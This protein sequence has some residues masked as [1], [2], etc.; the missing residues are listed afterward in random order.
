MICVECGAPAPSLI[1]K[2]TPSTVDVV[3]CSYCR[4]HPAD[5]YLEGPLLLVIQDLL[6]LRPQA[7]RHLIY[8]TSPSSGLPQPFSPSANH[9]RLIFIVASAIIHFAMIWS[10]TIQ[11]LPCFILPSNDP[12]AFPV[13]S[14]SSHAATLRL[15]SNGNPLALVSPSLSLSSL[16]TLPS[17]SR[18]VDVILPVSLARAKGCLL[19]TSSIDPPI[20]TAA[21]QVDLLACLVFS[22]I[23]TISLFIAH[24]T[25][26]ILS[27][28]FLSRRLTTFHDDSSIS[29]Q[30]SSSDNI[31]KPLS[32]LP[33]TINHALF[34]SSLPSLMHIFPLLWPPSIF[35]I[36]T[37]ASSSSSLSTFH[38]VYQALSDLVT[39]FLSLP[40][41]LVDLFVSASH[42]LALR[43]VWDATAF[44]AHSQR[45]QSLPPLSN[46]PLLDRVEH[47]RSPALSTSRSSL[48]F[49]KVS[50]GTDVAIVVLVGVLVR[51]LIPRLLLF[52]VS[53]SSL[54]SASPVFS[55][56]QHYYDAYGVLFMW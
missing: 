4:Y 48:R 11:T 1:T 52:L 25:M 36:S 40:S 53:S 41:R 30:P 39:H 51:S 56:P 26:S 3:S 7:Y 12:T 38:I 42:A 55:F 16:G 9:H 14:Y 23:A 2:V 49:P 27:Y 21:I 28:A 19:T 45:P 13:S 32:T 50:H 6:L 31:T 5:K 34:L 54:L 43:V 44:S 10:Y 35:P 15:A 20:P 17:F 47:P 29:A 18:Q 46:P 8:N 33:H 24:S 22:L 37:I